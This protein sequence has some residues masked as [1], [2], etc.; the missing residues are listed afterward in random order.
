MIVDAT[1]NLHQDLHNGLKGHQIINYLRYGTDSSNKRDYYDRDKG[2]PL[3]ARAPIGAVNHHKVT[4][5]EKHN[6][7]KGKKLTDV[8]LMKLR[9]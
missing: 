3:S 4:D 8:P 2:K 9:S 7:L 5:A 6:S 1:F